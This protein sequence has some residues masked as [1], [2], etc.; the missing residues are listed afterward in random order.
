MESLGKSHKNN[1]HSKWL[2]ELM[3]R[4][5][6]KSHDIFEKSEVDNPLLESLRLFDLLSEGVLRKAGLLADGQGGIDLNR[7]AQ[8]RKEGIPLE[9]ILG[10]A[11]FMGRLFHCSSATIIP[12]D[13]TETLVLTALDFIEKK[14][15]SIDNL[16]MIEM[17]TGCGNIAVTLALNSK[18]TKILA[19]DL[20]AD[21]VEIAQK[22][23]NKFNLKSR[24]SLFCGDLFE[25]FQ[26]MEYKGNVDLVVCNPPYFPT[27]SLNKLSSEIINYEPVLALDAGPYG[28]N[29]FRRLIAGSLDVLKPGGVLVFEIGEGQEKLVSRLFEKNKDYKNIRHFNDARI[30]RVISAVKKSE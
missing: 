23:V 5:F 8:K 21:A 26:N 11:A 12:M 4:N 24:V 9:Y 16:T 29:F 13:W 27:G 28:M 17:G 7:I 25:P 20:S 15:K 22:N 10:K 14:Q 19:S 3:F 18:N 1:A 6:V 2:V 30:V